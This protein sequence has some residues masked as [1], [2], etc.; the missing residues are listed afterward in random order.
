[1]NT[2]TVRQE[3]ETWRLAAC[4]LTLVY[5]HL[6]GQH[7]EGLSNVASRTCTGWDMG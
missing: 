4:L 6:A 7:V 1:M 2:K 3:T 5:M